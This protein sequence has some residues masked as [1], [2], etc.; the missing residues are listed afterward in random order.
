ML[1]HSTSYRQMGGLT[2]LWSDVRTKGHYEVLLSIGYTK[3]KSVLD[4]AMEE[5]VVEGF[6]VFSR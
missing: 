3:Q 4:H 6:F 1:S 2:D 5:S